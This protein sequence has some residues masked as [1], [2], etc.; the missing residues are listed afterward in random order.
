MNETANHTDN[1]GNAVT[2]E[3][4]RKIMER[5]ERMLAI[6]DDPGATPGEADTARTQAEALMFKYRLDEARLDST[7]KAKMGIRPTHRI[8][9]VC[10]L[11]SEFDA[12][13]RRMLLY[14]VAHVDGIAVT[15]YEHGQDGRT[16]LVMDVFGYES[17][18]A[19]AEVLWSAM[20][21]AFSKRLEPK[22][23]DSVDDIENVYRMRMAGMERAR[24]GIIMGW[25]GEGTKGPGKVTSLFKKGCVRHGE[26]ASLLLGKGNNVRTFR[27]SYASAFADE[28]WHRLYAL[29][30]SRGLDSDGTI[31]LANRADEIREFMYSVYP[32][33]RPQPVKVDPN[34]KPAKMPKFK[35]PKERP[36]N[37]VAQARGREAA[38]SV[39]LGPAA[40]GKLGN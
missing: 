32:S 18:I 25:G 16:M 36:V 19:Y 33:L 26:D 1:N 31:V 10:D 9:P 30:N 23:D 22:R 11:M 7:E 28:M 40:R 37:Y 39:D 34:A 35:M 38:R 8:I 27:R 20:R 21:I 12:D 5:V 6:A 29:R 24:I 13:Y 3:K 15:K 14:V 4:L 17:D 2:A